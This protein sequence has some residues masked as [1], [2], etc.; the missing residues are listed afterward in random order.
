MAAP[1]AGNEIEADPDPSGTIDRSMG[2][3]P[4]S[5]SLLAIVSVYLI[6]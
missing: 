1:T 3:P 4:S 5:I 6:S 2:R